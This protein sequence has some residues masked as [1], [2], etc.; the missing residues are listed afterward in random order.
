[1]ARCAHLLTLGAATPIHRGILLLQAPKTRQKPPDMSH[2]CHNVQTHWY[3]YQKPPTCHQSLGSNRSRRFC[4]FFHPF[5]GKPFSQSFCASSLAVCLVGL[6]LPPMPEELSCGHPTYW[7]KKTR[8]KSKKSG[9]M[10]KCFV[11]THFKPKSFG[12]LW[13]NAASSPGENGKW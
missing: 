12:T 6:A 7:R 10:L 3:R 2:M 9:E 13:P 11:T 5:F 8:R 1:M 4:K